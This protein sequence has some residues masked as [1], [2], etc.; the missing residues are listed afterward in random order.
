MADRLN[1]NDFE[2]LTKAANFYVEESFKYLNEIITIE[3]KNLFLKERI[4]EIQLKKSEQKLIEEFLANDSITSLR[5]ETK[6]E[7]LLSTD[8]LNAL[9]GAHDNIP[10]VLEGRKILRTHE[11]KGVKI[12]GHIVNLALFVEVMAH[13]HLFFLKENGNLN[14]FIYNQ[15]SRSN[16]LNIIIFI[17]RSEL[18]SEAI[19][20]D[21]VK[22][23]FKHR[24]FAVHHTPNN[25][26]K[27]NVK[28]STLINIWNQVI[29]LLRLF[30]QRE[31][32]SEIKFSK[33]VEN[34]KESFIET[35]T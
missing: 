30:E 20:I 9:L 28:I 33:R 10:K 3:L 6:I 11:I 18:E 31:R 14:N 17:C 16:I 2:L 35:W 4:S 5:N 32:F 15:F 21:A 8:T 22:L 13:R 23:L 19:K 12:L 1:I 25:A 24:N 26:K 27:I 34:E 29:E 7:S